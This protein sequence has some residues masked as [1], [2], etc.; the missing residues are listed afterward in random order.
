M[1]ISDWSSDGFS[2]DLASRS[3]EPGQAHSAVISTTSATSRNSVNTSRPENM[4]TARYP[5]HASTS[6]ARSERWLSRIS[7][8]AGERTAD[9]RSSSSANARPCGGK[10]SAGGAEEHTCEL[11][12]IM[13]TSH[14]LFP[15]KQ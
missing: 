7:S 13:H 2:S 14:A 10:A 6:D 3:K 1:R 11:Q 12:D 9:A 8:G 4:P 15:L 5:H